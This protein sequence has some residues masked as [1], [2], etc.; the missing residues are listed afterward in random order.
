MGIQSLTSFIDNYFDGKWL[1]YEPKGRLVIDGYSLCFTL[2]FNFNIDGIHGGQY[3]QYRDLLLTFFNCLKA[4]GVS[5]VTVFDGIDYKLEKQPELWRRRRDGV[6]VVRSQ[7][8]AGDQSRSGSQVLPILAIEVFREV[9]EELEVPLYFADGEADPDTVAVANYYKCPVVANDSDYYIFGAENGYIP[10]SRLR[11]REQ[12]I[13]AD[14]YMLHQFETA[15]NIK[16]P[17][18]S[19]MIPAMQGNDFM[20]RLYN[21]HLKEH[22][23]MSVSDTIDRSVRSSLHMLSLVL[24][25]SKFKT[26]DEVFEDVLTNVENGSRI[27]KAL[28]NNLHTAEEFY[29]ITY[30]LSEEE[31]MTKTV[32]RTTNGTEIPDWILRQ[33]RHGYFVSSL[34][35]TLVI[36]QCFLRIATDDPYKPSSQL[37]SR[38][39]R[40]SI[41]NILLPLIKGERVT[42]V[43]RFEADLRR[44]EV[45][46]TEST[47]FPS[48]PAVQ[49]LSLAQ[50]VDVLCNIINVDPKILEVFDRKWK[51]IICAGCYWVRECHPN[52]HLIKSLV[53]CL[54]FCSQA[55]NP[56]SHLPRHVRDQRNGK[57]MDALHKFSSFQCIYLDLSK[58]NNLLL[59]PFLIQSP[60]FLFDGKLAQF[61]SCK[62]DI[63]QIIEK[64][65]KGS[66][67]YTKILTTLSS[68][69]NKGKPKAST[70]EERKDTKKKVVPT[71][72]S[73]NPFAMLTLDSEEEDSDE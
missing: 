35:E 64:E 38:H 33:Y 29:N 63:D 17:R 20:N 65:F 6:K 48:F 28:S 39:I 73:S 25:L 24:Y 16:D 47:T 36:G 49:A 54:L 18:L 70:S 58:L 62:K 23:L 42:E 30:K 3:R 13:K 71:A 41:Y 66:S 21:S 7:L 15:F 8:T 9:L 53:M 55:R 50:R 68:F 14:V 31:L 72:I 10:I 19:R 46:C 32:L 2:Y 45:L 52:N 26:V 51:F 12:P 5:P 4:S 43:V 69:Q 37:A 27:V 40:Q 11:W 57:W 56:T 59:N 44:E 61:Y 1:R 67:L 34:M 22:I 60:A